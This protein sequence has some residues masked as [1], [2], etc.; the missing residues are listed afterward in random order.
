MAWQF[1]WLFFAPPVFLVNP[2]FGQVGNGIWVQDDYAGLQAMKNIPPHMPILYLY[3]MVYFNFNSK[4]FKE[5]CPVIGPDNRGLRY[6]DGLFETIRVKEG[7]LQLEDEHFSRLWKGMDTLQ[8]DRPRHFSPA[9]LSEE[10]KSLVKKNGH[11]KDA[12]IR[13]SIFRGDG[14]LYDSINLF[15]N[16]LIQ[17]WPL[18]QGYGDWN[19]NGLVLG[20]YNDALKSCDILSNIKHNNYL[21]S[22]LGALNAKKERWND[23]VILNMHGRVCETTIANVFIIKDGAFYTPS[24]AEGCVAG[25]MRKTV[26]SVLRRNGFTVE[27]VNIAMDD[28]LSAD[29]VFLT[30]SIHPLRWVQRIQNSVF[31]SHLSQTAFSLLVQTI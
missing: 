25:V 6:G 17:T 30:N 5:S 22:V 29:E 26:I 18:A 15:P 13:L 31:N 2:L 8:F 28:L 12:R 14:G 27:E 11:E 24:L 21:V 10:I 23:A 3:A 1:A 16:Y 20:V 4:I 19:S 9:L 7:L